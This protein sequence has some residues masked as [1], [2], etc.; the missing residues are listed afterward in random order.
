MIGFTLT[1]EQ[2][3]LQ[4]TARDFAD[5]YMRPYARE[6]D[7]MPSPHFDWKIIDRF[8]AHGM[9]SFFIPK[10]YGGLGLDAVSCAIVCEELAAACDG[11]QGVISGSM[12]VADCLKVGGTEEQ[13]RKYLT[14][15]SDKK[16]KV[17]AVGITEPNAGSDMQSISTRAIR[18]GDSY[19]ITG[20]KHYITNA[21]VADIYLIL[22]TIDPAR[23]YAA[24]DFFIVPGDSPGLS[25]GKVE[26]K[27]GQRASQN[28]DVILDNVRV[29]ADNLL[30]RPGTGFLVAMQAMD[31]KRP[32]MAICG[33]GIARAAYE[34]ALEYSKKRIQFGRPIFHNQAVAFALADMATQID[35]AR[36]MTWRACHLIDQ[37]LEFTRE[38]SMAK[39][40]ASECAAEVSSKAMHLMG[41]VGYSRD[42]PIEKYF[43]DAKAL[44]VIEG[45][46][47]IQRSIVAEQL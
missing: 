14:L 13:K 31:L 11:M 40:V 29:P 36:F 42:L 9:L 7:R 2:L 17:G 32:L 41:A 19:V 27:F 44:S 10:E 6:L 39:I 45:G 38:A 20:T 15:L 34:M 12:L 24:L 3:A 37:G 5:K 4:K 30:G 8:A 25:L 28:G 43:R 47:E 1:E 21:G 33:V 46:N 22:A 26:D 18:D 16:G 35:A 23:K